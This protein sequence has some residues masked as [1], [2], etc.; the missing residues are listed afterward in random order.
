MRKEKGNAVGVNSSA[1]Q[2]RQLDFEAINVAALSAFPAL[3]AR[4]LC[5]S[6]I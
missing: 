2:C 6:R 5:S 1:Y 3:L 4:W